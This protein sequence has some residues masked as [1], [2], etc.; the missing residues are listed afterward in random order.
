MCFILLASVLV[1]F[2]M[3]VILV[4]I[5]LCPVE[6]FVVSNHPIHLCLIA[7][8]T[9]E[10]VCCECYLAFIYLAKQAAL[11]PNEH[12]IYSQCMK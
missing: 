12:C 4:K 11:I 6:T 5:T 8:C 3:S 2:M 1:S 9:M 7:P 10:L